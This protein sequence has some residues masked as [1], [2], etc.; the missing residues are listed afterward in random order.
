MKRMGFVSLFGIAVLLLGLMGCSQKEDG[1]Y[2]YENIN[3]VRTEYRDWEKYSSNVASEDDQWISATTGQE[4][5]NEFSASLN[6]E[7]MK[8]VQL[9]LGYTFSVSSIISS[10]TG[11]S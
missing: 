1:Y 3:Y 7:L 6:V 10:S 4:V 5:E 9:E 2:G 11:V 8:T